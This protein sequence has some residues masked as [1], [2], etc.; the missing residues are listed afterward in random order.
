MG[1]EANST[2]SERKRR[3][4]LCGIFIV[5]KVTQSIPPCMELIGL[6]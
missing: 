2:S 3:L 6:L 1:R 5:K 4:E